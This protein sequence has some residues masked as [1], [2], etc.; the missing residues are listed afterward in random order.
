MARR[1]AAVRESGI[2]AVVAAAA[3]LERLGWLEQVA[4]YLDPTWFVPQVG[5]GAIA[6][7]ARAGSDV[8]A[9]L[10]ADLR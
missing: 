9:L 10:H 7:E 1:L 3:A 4:E 5:Q 2:D 8:A 6:V